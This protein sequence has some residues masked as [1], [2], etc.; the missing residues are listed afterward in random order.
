LFVL[1]RLLTAGLH[2]GTN[3]R[4]GKTVLTAEAVL[5]EAA[6]ADQSSRTLRAIG[7]E[8]LAA[9]AQSQHQM[10]RRLLLDVVVRE[11]T[12]VLELFSGEDETLL[13]GWDAFLVL[14]FGLDVLDRVG[15]FDFERDRLAGEGLHEDL[16]TTTEAENQ[17][18]GRLL[19]NVIVGQGTTVLQ[20]LTSEDE[21]LLIWGNA[22]LVLNLSLYVLNSIRGF[23][24]KS[25]G[26][27]SE[28]LD[29]DL[30]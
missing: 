24:I 4:F 11:G 27:A 12:T 20:L 26:L 5:A 18:K 8:A 14:D 28:C 10:E 15:R 19:L 25:D 29:E 30:H 17:V 9:T 16:H 23:D 13:V 1:E 2:L 22:F 7:E 21:T 6:I 3:V